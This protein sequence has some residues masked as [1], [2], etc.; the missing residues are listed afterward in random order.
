MIDGLEVPASRRRQLGAGLGQSPPHLA[1]RQPADG[2]RLVGPAGLGRLVG[3]GLQGSA[4]I[5]GDAAD[6][7]GDLDR[8]GHVVDEV[9]QHPEIDQEQAERDRHRDVGH[10]L[11]GRG[12]RDRPEGED[13]EHE[14]GDEDAEGHLRADV[15]DEVAQH[16]RAE[17]G[18][19]QRQGD[20]G[21]REDHTDNGDHGRRDRRQDGAGGIRST[22]VQPRGQRC[23]AIGVSPIDPEGHGEE[24]H[25]QEDE[26]GR[27]EPE[28]RA[29][30]LGPEGGQ[31]LT[32]AH[33]DR[34]GLGTA[35]ARA[36]VGPVVV[37]STPT[38]L[39]G[40]PVRQAS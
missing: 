39:P 6:H 26:Q 19:G 2:R 8:L 9:D 22:V 5:V 31:P 27:N 32:T 29:Q 21:D 24:D 3:D 35:S 33:H 4:E 23:R 38:R 7:L 17:L 16:P 13:A 11:G 40:T 20:D 25:R 28:R 10:E 14:G 18:G 36:H 1:E 12:A 34:L 15:T 37:E 30:R